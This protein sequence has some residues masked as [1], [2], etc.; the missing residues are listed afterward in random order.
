MA[1]ASGPTPVTKLTRLRSIPLLQP[2]PPSVNA[3]VSGTAVNVAPAPAFTSLGKSRFTAQPL[4]FP[5]PA[6]LSL[7]AG[8]AAYA[9]APFPAAQSMLIAPS[10]SVAGAAV[11]TGGASNALL[12]PLSRRLPSLAVAGHGTSGSAHGS[13]RSDA[14]N[15]QPPVVLH[16]HEIEDV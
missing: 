6:A 11:P 7:P 14:S 4:P 5:A 1:A 8:S 15:Q 16:P 3:F 2:P 9:F 12:P 13:A 10:L